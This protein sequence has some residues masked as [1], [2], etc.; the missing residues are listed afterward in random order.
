MEVTRL[1]MCA[2]CAQIYVLYQPPV[3]TVSCVNLLRL[4]IGV[5]FG[6]DQ[7]YVSSQK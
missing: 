7:F 6:I 2:L 3:F 4:K 1:C 5:R